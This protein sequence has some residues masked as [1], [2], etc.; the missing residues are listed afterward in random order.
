MM[1]ERTGKYN[2]QTP[3][4]WCGAD[5]TWKDVWLDDKPP[6]AARV[7]VYRLG[8]PEPLWAIAVYK[9]YVQKKKD[10]S[11]NRMWAT[12]PSNQLLK[13]AE[14]LALR[15]AFP[16]LQG[17]YGAEEM[18]QAD[19]NKPAQITEAAGVAPGDLLATLMQEVDA[20]NLAGTL[21]QWKDAQTTRRRAALLPENL[22]QNLRDHIRS[23]L[24]AADVKS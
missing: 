16:E 5:G 21:I 3:P 23:L 4:Q 13:C 18:E 19:N 24:E 10:G 12:M 22:L 17:V 9:E 20:A 1:A 15:K 8:A 11:P 6:S 7:G 2:G 14:G